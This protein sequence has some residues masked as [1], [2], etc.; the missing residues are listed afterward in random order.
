MRKLFTLL[1]AVLLTASVVAQSPEKMS[2]QA[3]VR[4]ASNVLITNTQVGMQISILQTTATGTA[5]YVETQTPT[6]NANGL[7]SLEIGSG[8][9]VSGTFN[10]IDWS[11]GPYF[12]KTETDPTGGTTYTITGTSQLMSVPYALYA[13][14]SG[15]AQDING[16]TDALV[17]SGSIYIGEDPSQSTTSA[18]RNTSLGK[19]AL[20]SI[21]SGNQNTAIGYGALNYNN[22]GVENVAVG[23]NSLI[24]NTSGM[25]NIGIGFVSLLSNSTGSGNVAVGT[26]ALEFNTHS[27]NLALGHYA[28][29]NNTTGE[30]NIGIGTSSGSI[31]T[32]GG[33][34]TIIGNSA[35][36]SSDNAINQIVIGNGAIGSG[37]N[38]VQLGNTNINNVRT[39]GTITAGA[40]TIPNTDGNA[41]QVLSTDGN[42]NLSW[43]SSSGGSSVF[44]T[45]NN[46]TSNSNGDLLNDDFVFG[47]STP[48]VSTTN[49]ERM[50]FDKSLAAFRA[51]SSGTGS[52]NTGYVGQYSAAFG[53]HTRAS[54]SWSFAAGRVCQATDIAAVAMGSYATASGNAAISLGL[55]T[56]AS[57]EGS[58]A[59]GFYSTAIGIRSVSIGD[60]SSSSAFS[61]IAVGSNVN[62]VASYEL[63]V[64]R[65]NTPYT[66]AT[67]GFNTWNLNDRLFT[68]GNGTGVGAES[69]AMIVRKSGDTEI[70]GNVKTSGDVHL[71]TISSGVIL[72][73]PNGSCWKLT[74]DNSGN[75]VTT[76]VTCP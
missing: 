52:W 60:N 13:K 26:G 36:P 51:G 72:T 65:Y 64:G 37:D 56:D 14:T 22:S 29:P 28:L 54:D 18:E 41:G 25:Q 20:K 49:F 43:Q 57:A 9:V 58:V 2:Y 11:A 50:F 47:A 68:I 48:D 31:L 19:K 5:V 1:V 17:E 55:Y 33:D 71:S 73:S 7:L 24:N 45:V 39:S 42:G 35:N 8:T 74:V 30:G 16:L 62:S 59:L 15:N 32:T 6:S 70:N 69:D 40:I 27:N 4:G 12:I 38:T 67:T 66:P 3:V 76:S 75:I 53:E 10:T 21:T 23:M 44:T 34:N 46:V 63:V 61:S